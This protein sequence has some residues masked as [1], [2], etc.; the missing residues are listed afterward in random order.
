MLEAFFYFAFILVD[1]TEKCPEPGLAG[2]FAKDSH[3][4]FFIAAHAAKHSL[5]SNGISLQKTET[6]FGRTEKENASY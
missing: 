4:Y 5:N 2:K 6:F 3:R 1:F